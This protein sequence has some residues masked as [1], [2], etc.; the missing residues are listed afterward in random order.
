[1][2]GHTITARREGY[3]LYSN[4]SLWKEAGKHSYE[5]GF[6][7]DAC[8]DNIDAAIDAHEEEIRCLLAEAREEFGN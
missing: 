7:M 2:R 3:T 4:G 1:M 5:A 6:L 8:E